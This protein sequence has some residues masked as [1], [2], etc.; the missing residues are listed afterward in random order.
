MYF[1]KIMAAFRRVMFLSEVACGLPYTLWVLLIFINNVIFIIMRKKVIA[2]IAALFMA[3]T[4]NA[5]FEQGKVYLGGSLTGLNLKYSGIDNLSLGLQAQ[6]GYMFDDNLMLLGQVAYDHNGGKGSK[7]NVSFGV[8]G[9]Y[10]IEQNGIYLGVNCKYIHGS[11]G[12]NDVMPG[13]EV[14]YVFFLSRTVTVEPAIYYDQSFKNHSDY[15]TIG[16]KIGLGVYLFN[17]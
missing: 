10:Y 8:G 15:S 2:M 11:H 13:V 9:R 17:D 6:A 4:A 16:L 12:Y 5:Q 7:N 1:C 3:V 14:G